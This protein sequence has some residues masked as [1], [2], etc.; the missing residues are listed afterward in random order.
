MNNN[1]KFINMTCDDYYENPTN[2][3]NNKLC[4]FNPIL[5]TLIVNNKKRELLYE[6]KNN[7]NNINIQDKDGDTPLHIAMFLCNYEIIKILLDNGAD[8]NIKDKWGQ[9][10]VHRLYFGIKDDDI[11]KIIKL[12]EDKNI[13][14]SSIDILGNTVLH[15]TLK[16]IIKF[17][18]PL[19][20]KH[21]FFINKLKSLI[22]NDIR[23]NE[24]YSI[25]D[26]LEIIKF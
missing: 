3:D 14:F 11:N 10:I 18:T 2:I 24:N 20:I 5:F 21:K 19:T 7:K 23:N 22:P 9:T 1:S 4:L 12:L 25:T 17:N 16:Q 13:N 6:L 15:L 8:T 26:L